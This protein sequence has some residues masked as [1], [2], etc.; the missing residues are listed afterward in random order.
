MISS[1]FSMTK[2]QEG[3][4]GSDGLQKNNKQFLENSIQQDQELFH[5]SHNLMV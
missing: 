5:Q 4:N 3:V 1:N 2:N